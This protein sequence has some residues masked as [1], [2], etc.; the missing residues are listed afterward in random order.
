MAEDSFRAAPAAGHLP[1]PSVA[2]ANRWETWG[3]WGPQECRVSPPTLRSA[4]VLVAGASP[5]LVRVRDDCTVEKM[6]RGRL[7]EGA[8]GS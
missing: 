6:K 8:S 1:G 7:D 3:L 5:W 4:R 2:G